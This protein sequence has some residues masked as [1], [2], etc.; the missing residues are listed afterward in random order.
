MYLDFLNPKIWVAR[1][2]LDLVSLAMM[3]A[4]ISDPPGFNNTMSKVRDPYA[5]YFANF[6]YYCVRGHLFSMRQ[7][8]RAQT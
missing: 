5:S 8:L 2:M 4:C 7:S 3:S 6:F 1:S